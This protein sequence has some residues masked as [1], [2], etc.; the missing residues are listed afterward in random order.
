MTFFQTS[1]IATA[2]A[3]LLERRLGYADWLVPRF[4]HP[5]VWIGNLIS[6]LETRLNREDQP[7]E[8]RRLMG[9]VMLG[10]VLLVVGLLSAGLMMLVRLWKR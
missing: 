7:D 4:G 8:R 5:V 2:L 10:S 1:L 9:L 3:L 6:W